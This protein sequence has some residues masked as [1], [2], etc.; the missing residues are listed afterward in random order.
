MTYE[1]NIVIQSIFKN[2]V[3]H[4]YYKYILSSRMD[5]TETMI[6]QHFYWTAIRNV[7]QKEVNILTLDNV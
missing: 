4:W 2:Y 6:F 1:D 5:R 3:L 7:V